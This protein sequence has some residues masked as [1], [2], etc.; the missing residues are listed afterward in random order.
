LLQLIKGFAQFFYRQHD[1]N[2][3]IPVDKAVTR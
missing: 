2:A 1:A 3:S